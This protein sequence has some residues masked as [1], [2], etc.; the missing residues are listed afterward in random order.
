MRHLG[1]D[2]GEKRT[3]IAASDE[4]GKIAFP[5][6]TLSGDL[7]KIIK[8][9]KE[10]CVKEKVG[11]IIVGLPLSFGGRE[12]AQTK[13]AKIFAGKLEKSIGLPVDFEN[14]ILTSKMVERD[15]KE[16]RIKKE[17]I[18]A[19]SAAIILQSYLDKHLTIN[20]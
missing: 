18:D 1:V 11:R 4:G 19:A 20:N 5:R 9:I 15:I 14:E 10:I 16:G 8:K 2:F 13:E 3:G 6:E 12:T 17:K 7:E